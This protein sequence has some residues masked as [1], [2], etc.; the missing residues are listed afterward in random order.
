M[1]STTPTDTAAHAS[2]SGD[3]RSVPWAAS[4]WQA[5][6]RATYAPQMLAVRVPP[7]ACSTSQSSVIWTSP[8]AFRSVTARSARPMRRW[9]SWVRPDWRPRAASRSIRSGLEPGSIEYSAVTQPLP[10]PRIHLGT[11]LATDA[12]QSTLVRPMA[13]S[14]EPAANSV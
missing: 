10:V 14:T 8:M 6:W 2:V 13:T 5:S 3:T 9:I 11:S 12:V 1:A 4:R 7:S